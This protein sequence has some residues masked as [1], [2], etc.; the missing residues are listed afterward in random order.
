MT[1][2]KQRQQWTADAANPPGRNQKL[3]FDRAFQSLSYAG[4][5]ENQIGGII[6]RPETYRR[7]NWST[8]RDTSNTPGEDLGEAIGQ[9]AGWTVSREN[10]RGLTSELLG[11]A[12]TAN[13]ATPTKDNR[14]TQE[15]HDR[16]TLEQ[17]KLTAEQHA[18]RDAAQAAAAESH[19]AILAKKPAN[20]KALIVAELDKDESDGMSDY[21]SHKTLRRVAIGWRTTGRESFPQLRKAALNF[22]ETAHLGPNAE[23]FPSTKE[24]PWATFDIEH[25]DNGCVCSENYLK[26]GHLHSD[27]WRVSSYKLKHLIGYDGCTSMT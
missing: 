18:R 14:I 22:P 5:G 17:N 11:A 8:S 4:S 23:R 21:F 24:M 3:A 25:R 12:T 7:S 26:K 19:A 6:G 1:D 27:G 15:E 10:V 20:A 2:T 9:A 16:K 13:A